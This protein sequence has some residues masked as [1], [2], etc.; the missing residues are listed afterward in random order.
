MNKPLDKINLLYSEE[1]YKIIG[2][3]MEVY[4]QLG[5]GFLEAVYQEALEIELAE[6]NIP[7]VAQPELK[8]FYKGKQLNKFYIADFMVYDKIVLEIKAISDI[9]GI[10]EAQLLNELQ[11]TNHKVG[12]L[13]NFGCKNGLDWHRKIK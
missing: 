1:T 4:N 2:A 8:V 13:I 7:F 9:T 11:A 10:E 6:R 12:L 3:A 5:P